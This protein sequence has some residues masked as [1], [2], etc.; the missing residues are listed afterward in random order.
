MP[1]DR[2]MLVYSGL[3]ADVGVW[4]KNVPWE[5]KGNSHRRH[6]GLHSVR[7]AGKPIALFHESGLT[8]AFI[9]RGPGSPLQCL[10]TSN[11]PAPYCPPVRKPIYRGWLF[12]G[13][14]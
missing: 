4:A 12:T 14:N 8:T 3:P 10:G 2:F 6:I 7:I 5:F 13:L 9:N 1:R 11:C